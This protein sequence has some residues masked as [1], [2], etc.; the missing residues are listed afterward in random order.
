MPLYFY[1]RAIRSAVF[2]AAGKR[3]NGCA[4]R[5]RERDRSAA[6][7]EKDTRDNDESVSYHFMHNSICS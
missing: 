6:G 7:N 2:D 5:I 3:W 4:L 1:P